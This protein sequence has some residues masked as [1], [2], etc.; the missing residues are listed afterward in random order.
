MQGGWQAEDRAQAEDA[1]AQSHAHELAIRGVQI[2]SAAAAAA[3]KPTD[4]QME[5]KTGPTLQFESLK[6]P[7]AP[8]PQAWSVLT[9]MARIASKAMF[10]ATW[11]GGPA[12]M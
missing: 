6:G 9:L 8:L 5:D 3:G 11:H 12:S 1:V 2:T 4:V 10:F 7:L